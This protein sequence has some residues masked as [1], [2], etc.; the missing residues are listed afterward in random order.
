MNRKKYYFIIFLLLVIF[1][2]ISSLNFSAENFY[3]YSN[4]ISFIDDP[5]FLHNV[6]GNVTFL[7]SLGSRVTGYTGY[8]KAAEYIAK[9]FEKYGLKPGGDSNTYFQYYNVSIPFDLGAKIRVDKTGRV[10]NAYILWPNNVQVSK[11]IEPGLKGRLIYVDEGS[12]SDLKGKNINGSIVL[13]KFNSYMNWLNVVK[14]GAKAIIFIEPETSNR[15]E[16]ETKFL[17]TPIYVPRLYVNRSVGEELIKISKE[18][19]VVTLVSLMEYRRIIAKNVIGIMEGTKYKND[20]IVISSYFDSWS[21]VP[22]IAPGADEATGI[23]SLFEIIRY[24]KKHPP[25]RTIWFVAFS[26]HWQALSGSRW[27]VEKY[28][29]SNAV[30]SDKLKIWVHINLD[31]STDSDTVAYLSYGSMYTH[32]GY[33][34]QFDGIFSLISKDV[35]S[36]LDKLGFNTTQYIENIDRPNMYMYFFHDA[37][38]TVVAGSAGITFRTSR[39][40]RFYW[41]TPFNTLK[42]VKFTNLIPQMIF[43][44]STIYTIVNIDMLPLKWSESGVKPARR[45]WI[46]FGGGSAKGYAGVIGEVTRYDVEKKWYTFRGLENYSILVD[47]A[48]ASSRYNP[49]CHI[50]VNT[51]KNG[52]FIVPGIGTDFIYPESGYTAG[53]HYKYTGENVPMARAYAYLFNDK[54]KIEWVN[55]FGIW[56]WPQNRG[57]LTDRPNGWLPLRISVFKGKEVVLFDVI[58]PSMLDYPW[59]DFNWRLSSFNRFKV[60]SLQGDPIYL[61][62]IMVEVRDFDT[63]AIPLYYFVQSPMDTAE[64]IAQIFIPENIRFEI[65]IYNPTGIVGILINASESFP[66]GQG[67]NTSENLRFYVPLEAAKNLYY[68]NEKRYNLLR[69]YG[70]FSFWEEKARTYAKKH[71]LYALKAFSELDYKKAHGASLL[72]WGWETKVYYETKNLI[73]NLT[74]TFIFFGVLLVPFSLLLDRLLFNSQG[75]KRIITLSLSFIVPYIFLALIHPGFAF[76]LNAPIATEAFILMFFALLTVLILSGHFG[77][78]LKEIRKKT[79]GAHFVEISRSEAFMMSLSLGIGQMKRRKIRSFLVLLTVILVTFALVMLTSASGTFIS[80]AKVTGSKPTYEGMLVENRQGI[81]ILSIGIVEA[82]NGFENKTIIGS[83]RIWIYPTPFSTIDPLTEKPAFYISANGRKYEIWGVLGL[84]IN[85]P[86]VTGFDK[87][88][89][90]PIW[91]NPWYKNVCIISKKTAEELG[92]DIGSTITFSSGVKLTVI[93]FINEEI[94]PMLYDLDGSLFTPVD[95]AEL[96]RELAGAPLTPEMMREL[97]V[98]IKI[99]LDRIVIIPASLAR[100]LGGSLRG[101]AFRIIG[102]EE[103]FSPIASEITLLHTTL[104]SFIGTPQSEK[105]YLYTL[106]LMVITQGWQFIWMPLIISALIIFNTVMGAIYERTREIKIM[107]ALGLAPIHVGGIFLSETFIYSVIGSTLGYLFGI[108][109]TRIFVELKMLPPN[110]VPSFASIYAIVIVL[111]ILAFTLL[112]V[113]YPVY[114]AST[115]VIPSFERRFKIKSKPKETLWEITTPFSLAKEEIRGFMAFM[116]EYFEAFMVQDSAHSF[117]TLVKPVY[118]EDVSSF[119]DRRYIETKVILVPYDANITQDVKI[120]AATRTGGRRY[121]VN[122]VM[123]L[124]T[125][126]VSNWRNANQRF[127]REVRKQLLLWRG[128]S[129]SE[130]LHY[131]KI[132]E[133][134]R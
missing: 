29:F 30:Q 131:L 126:S 106:S 63:H 24:F 46:G 58:D 121:N 85:E 117:T 105:T 120:I 50:I 99:P 13:M 101:Y 122:I 31:F 35:L 6:K 54:G 124:L 113:L 128:L 22:K 51:D 119:Y 68:L 62:Q 39:S 107:S 118:Q 116:K 75:K 71:Y 60:S 1:S 115:L 40:Y 52:K 86:N 16:A 42:I 123:E 134:L 14:F 133:S 5:S 112:S 9:I 25:Q 49:Y 27:F 12:L 127:I 32:T 11:I 26:G 47:I 74:T 4:V 90:T 73:Y 102:K 89:T 81:D 70:F 55:D 76:A 37:E 44:L 84:G 57:F 130:K 94:E 111:L 7:A 56:A 38:P 88:M 129:D 61:P 23:A 8:E 95:F 65:L 87:A 97:A 36:S 80:G 125:G 17:L 2:S 79:I 45:T 10:Y 100:D 103:K 110:F 72:F 66:E 108:L 28:Y 83:E 48:V 20:I 41:N 91:F 15:I 98:K 34:G 69:K 53:A 21:I 3:D 19:P 82:I 114:K 64:P 77:S 109:G 33:Y 93:G 92:V 59:V 18:T 78:I 96:Q 132:G 104:A 67:Y 43:S